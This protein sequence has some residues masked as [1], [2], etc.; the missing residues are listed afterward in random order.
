MRTIPPY[1]IY[2]DAETTEQWN[3]GYI[4]DYYQGIDQTPLS[5]NRGIVLPIHFGTQVANAYLY[6]VT[7]EAGVY[8]EESGQQHGFVAKDVIPDEVPFVDKT[9]VFLGPMRSEHYGHFLVEAT[10]RLWYWQLSAE[11]DEEC[12]PV[13]SYAATSGAPVL[14]SYVREFMDLYGG[15][16]LKRAIFITQPT[17]FARVLVPRAACTPSYYSE[18]ALL[19]FQRV[20]AAVPAGAHEKVYLSRTQFRTGVGYT[21]GEEELEKNFALN[22]FHIVYPEQ[23]NLRE[24]VSI[25]KGARVIAGINGTALHNLLFHPGGADVIILQRSNEFHFWQCVINQ[26][27][28]ATTHQCRVY[29]R[30]LPSPV[31]HFG[32]FMLGMTPW[33]RE[34]FRE[35]G[36]KVDEQ[37][38]RNQKKYLKAYLQD[39]RRICRAPWYTPH[40]KKTRL[41]F[42]EFR[43]YL[44]LE[45]ICRATPARIFWT[46]LLSHLTFGATK[47]RLREAYKY[48]LEVKKESIELTDN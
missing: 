43:H 29:E 22:G 31:T 46:R 4:K 2:S 34:F 6:G 45:E 24:Q 5:V 13:F 30:V 16:L 32:P 39:F 3:K 19:P 27:I 14:P 42:E 20:A 38:G 37:Q 41:T 17:R 48:M 23:L 7:D 25:I 33:V 40:R 10:A 36:L 8:I 28:H 35:Y 12:V 21:H 44:I 15:D 47:K 26:A 9:A 18:M 1:K 11:H